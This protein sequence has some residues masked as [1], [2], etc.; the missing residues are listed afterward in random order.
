MREL[1]DEHG[2]VY[3]YLSDDGLQ[4]EE[5]SFTLCTFWLVDNLAMQA[6]WMKLVLCLNICYPMLAI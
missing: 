2:F 1:T 3:R 6:V 4:G 5:G